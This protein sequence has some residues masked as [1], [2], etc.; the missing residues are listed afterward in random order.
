MLLPPLKKNHMVLNDESVT[1]L[2][3]SFPIFKIRIIYTAKV[4]IK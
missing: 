4:G 3:L 2:K 1:P